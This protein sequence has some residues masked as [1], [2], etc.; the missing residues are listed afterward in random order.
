MNTSG[1]VIAIALAGHELGDC[2]E[3][4]KQPSTMAPSTVLSPQGSQPVS[5]ARQWLDS[6]DLDRVIFSGLGVRQ[7]PEC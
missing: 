3:A 1:V 4:N 7:V 5:A 6:L 2:V